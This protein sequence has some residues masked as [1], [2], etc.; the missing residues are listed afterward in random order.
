M[1]D[2]DGLKKDSF[3]GEWAMEIHPQWLFD[4]WHKSIQLYSRLRLPFESDRLPALNGLAKHLLER[5][6]GEYVAAGGI[7]EENISADLMWKK[8][9]RQSRPE[10]WNAPSWSWARDSDPVVFS[11]QRTDLAFLFVDKKSPV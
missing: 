10:I 1:L 2:G 11:T 8:P 7:W 5:G 9:G 3:R 4:L 6:C